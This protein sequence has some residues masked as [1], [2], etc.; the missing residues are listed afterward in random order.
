LVP[1]AARGQTQCPCVQNT[2]LTRRSEGVRGVG[3][4]VS[5]WHKPPVRCSAPMRR[6][7]EE[8]PTFGGRS[9]YR[10]ARGEERCHAASR[11]R[12]YGVETRPLLVATIQRL[13]HRTIESTFPNPGTVSPLVARHCPLGPSKTAVPPTTSRTVQPSMVVGLVSGTGA[14]LG[15]LVPCWMATARGLGDVAFWCVA[16][17]SALVDAVAG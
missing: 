7:S 13:P 3:V 1:P 8:N 14:S 10:R 6:L 9:Q 11:L 16:N 12:A 2:W 17:V 15:K 5:S 4:D